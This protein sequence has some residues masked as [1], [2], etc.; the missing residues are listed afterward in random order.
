MA[1]ARRVTDSDRHQRKRASIAASLPAKT[2][3]TLEEW[4]EIARAAPT[5][6]FMELV[7]WLKRECGLGHFQAV[8]VAEEARPDARE[9]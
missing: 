9:R 4:A 1:D 8:R 6:G 3:R 2:G 5:A 7:G